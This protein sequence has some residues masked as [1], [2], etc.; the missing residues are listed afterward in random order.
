[1]TWGPLQPAQIDFSD[2]Q[3]PRAPAFDDLYHTRSG[4]DGQAQHV[5]LRGSG[6]PGRWAGRQRFVVLETGFGLGSNFLATWAAWQQDPQ[7][8]DQ[9]WYVAVEKHPPRADDLARAHAHTPHR[10]QLDALLRAWPPLTPDMHLLD[11]EGGRVR[12]LLAFG[13]I[14]RVLPDLVLQANAF[15]LDGFAP[16]RNPAMWDPHLLR[17]LARLAAPGASV[18]TWTVAS[19]VRQGLAAAGFV[20]DKQQGFTGK[21]EM[22]AGRF[23]PRFIP[24]A[25]PGRQAQAGVR[26]V[27]VVGA[28][29]A[30]CAVSAALA[31]RGLAVQL[32][33]S[34]P[35]PA[36]A[37]SG[38]AGGLFHGVVHAQD[39]P[40]ARWLRAAAL[41][42]A[43]V[44]RPLV[45]SSQVPGQVD[46]LL[47]GERTLS[48]QA[49]QQLIDALALPAGFLQ[50]TNWPG[51]GGGPAWLYPDGGWAAPAALC[52]AW[53]DAPGITACF[54]QSV[55]TLQRL[56]D[57]WQLL[58]E[59][60]GE[61]LAEAD[62]VVLCNAADAQRLAGV[63]GDHWT[64][65][66]ARGQTTLLPAT[67]TGLPTLPQPLA[68]GGYVLQLA[69]GRW[70]CG[71]T[72]QRDDADPALRPADHHNN[73]DKLRRLTGWTGDIDPALLD[74]RVG[75]RL[76]TDDRL[77]L[78]GPLPDLAAGGQAID[79]P[80]RMPRQPGLWV[81]TALG[82]R[83]LT[84][85]ALGAEVLASWLTGDPVPAPAALLDALD[86]A[87][88]ATRAVRR[89]ARQSVE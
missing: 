16:A 34:A 17:Q 7:R 76:Q 67:T 68:D 12:L 61:V 1:M 39:G 59:R 75:W 23:T 47:R 81:F 56:G 58:S 42:M 73:L 6:L 32:I 85:A 78:L 10:A 11:F 52:A 28:G 82:S 18:A 84:Q 5:F 4:A 54:G 89:A 60:Q 35:G 72:S 37:T 57:R 41:H 80:R 86:P 15:Y 71:A 31:A 50:I 13:D 26:Q 53:L 25:P 43:R 22:T 77:P 46:G 8:C 20:V 33:D 45:A 64:L 29:L 44:L 65:G 55:A 49:M 88:F 74:G 38:N 83:G 70:L 79:Q 40:H 27:A 62:A 87:R 36:H 63:S 2:A 19:A 24:P 21:R 51:P 66:L 3:A 69:D 9:L 14:H 48:R 30:G